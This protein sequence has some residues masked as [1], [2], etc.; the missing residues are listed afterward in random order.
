MNI[1]KKI[2]L[3]ALTALVATPYVTFAGETSTPASQWKKGWTL[4]KAAAAVSAMVAGVYGYV[5][6]KKYNI[7]QRQAF[8]KKETEHVHAETY[9]VNDEM[10]YKS[11]FAS[12]AQAILNEPEAEWTDLNPVMI[13]FQNDL[14]SHAEWSW[15]L[16]NRAFPFYNYDDKETEDLR[17]K[18]RQVS[19]YINRTQ[20]NNK[21]KNNKPL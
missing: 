4:A 12:S 20:F 1:M 14:A 3:C 18:T 21:L 17:A 11:Q 13:T 19:E 6:I 15:W 8:I 9:N 7:Q 5:A 16:N 2:I 10:K